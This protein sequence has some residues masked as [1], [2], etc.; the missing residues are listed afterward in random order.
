MPDGAATPQPGATLGHP[1]VACVLFLRLCQG[2]ILLLVHTQGR[3]P[4]VVCLQAKQLTV[5][6]QFS[7]VLRSAEYLFR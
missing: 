2:R 7:D 6:H 3:L 4:L 5:V 1:H